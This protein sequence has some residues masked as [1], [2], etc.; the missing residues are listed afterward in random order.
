MPAITEQKVLV[1]RIKEIYDKFS[2]VMLISQKDSSFD[3]EFGIVRG[4]GNLK[5]LY[6]LIPKEKEIFQGDIVV[7]SALGGIFPQ[8]LLVGKIRKVKKND[9]ESFQQA[10]IQPG[11]NV[12]QSERLFIIL[13]F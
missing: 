9:V 13:D 2:K 8:G 4:Q 3:A 7:T 1:G 10:E 6:D 11:F 12:S 5:L